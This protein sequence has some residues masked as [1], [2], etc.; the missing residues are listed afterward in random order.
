[1]STLKTPDLEYVQLIKYSNENFMHCFVHGTFYA[2]ALNYLLY[3]VYCTCL[4]C[5]NNPCLK[6]SFNIH[7]I[8]KRMPLL[9]TEQNVCFYVVTML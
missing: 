6:S 5:K 7:I 4:Q 9:K 3:R 1:M 2:S 8:H